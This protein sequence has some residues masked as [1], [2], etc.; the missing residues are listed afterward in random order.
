MSAEESDIV[1]E[2]GTEEE[3]E[4]GEEGVTETEEKRADTLL[5]K[6]LEQDF[7]LESIPIVLNNAH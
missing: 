5:E 2:R 7:C 3:N 4:E 6:T 1:E